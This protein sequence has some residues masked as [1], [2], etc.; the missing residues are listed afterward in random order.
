SF[1]Q[2]KLGYARPRTTWATADG[3]GGSTPGSAPV[4]GTLSQAGAEKLFA[5]ARV[6]WATIAKLSATE[7]PR[8]RAEPLAAKLDVVTHTSFEAQSS[9]NVA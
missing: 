9:S 2:L 8:F 7:N 4:L 1:A 5:G 3:L 6:P